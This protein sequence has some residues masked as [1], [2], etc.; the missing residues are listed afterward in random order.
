M[1]SNEGDMPAPMLL[2]IDGIDTRREHK[3][4]A[5]ESLIR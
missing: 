2:Q 3:F 4:T 5:D 1:R